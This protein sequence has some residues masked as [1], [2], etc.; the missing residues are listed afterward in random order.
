[1]V[2]PFD[3]GIL[4]IGDAFENWFSLLSADC[5]YSCGRIV[6]MLMFNFS[7]VSVVASYQMFC[8]NMEISRDVGYLDMKKQ[9]RF[10]FDLLTDLFVLLGILYIGGL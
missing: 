10:Q 7:V 3:V 2:C 5:S 4:Q 9:S 8:S 6:L 1:M